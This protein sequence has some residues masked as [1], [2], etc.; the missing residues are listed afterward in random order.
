MHF[1]LVSPDL[2]PSWVC[3][4]L[5][6]TSPSMTLWS[7]IQSLF[8]CPGPRSSGDVTTTPSPQLP[9]SPPHPAHTDRS[10]VSVEPPVATHCEFHLCVNKFWLVELPPPA[11][12]QTWHTR[13]WVKLPRPRPPSSHSHSDHSSHRD[14]TRPWITRGDNILLLSYFLHLQ[15]IVQFLYYFYLNPHPPSPRTALCRFSRHPGWLPAQAT[16]DGLIG[17]GVR[18]R[19]RAVCCLLETFPSSDCLQSGRERGGNSWLH[20]DIISPSFV[21]NLYF[22]HSERVKKYLLILTQGPIFY[23]SQAFIC[24]KIF[25]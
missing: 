2:A 23:I 10:E 24:I 19:E 20:W 8:I 3:H 18:E 11:F 12:V 5:A 16:E 13:C 22:W 1:S 14:V 4:D 21:L 17:C 9:V 6:Q 7:H 25:G 15:Y